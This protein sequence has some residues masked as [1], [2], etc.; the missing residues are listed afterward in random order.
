MSMTVRLATLSDADDIASLTLQLG[1]HVESTLL[2]ARLSRFLARPD[3]RFLVAELDARVVGWVHAIL[4]ECIEAGTYVTIGGLVV[5]R[6][7]RSRGIGRVLIERAEEWAR[8]EGCSMVR[9]WSTT[10]RSAAHRFYERHGYSKIKTQ[11]AFAKAL[12]GAGHQLLGG[13][14]PRLGEEA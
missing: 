8:E 10:A 6:T 14:A 12:D 1:Y 13:L 5:E 4:S 3:H 7:H 2:K 9:L 11:Y